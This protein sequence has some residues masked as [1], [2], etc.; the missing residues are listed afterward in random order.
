MALARL[1]QTPSEVPVVDATGRYSTEP[2]ITSL[3]CETSSITAYFRTTNSHGQSRPL[4]SDHRW[5]IASRSAAGA[6]EDIDGIAAALARPDGSLT[7]LDNWDRP[8]QPPPP[9]RG[10]LGDP[11]TADR[12]G[13]RL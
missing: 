5:L 4:Q 13:H 3:D 12:G 7:E 9:A 1:N 2:G 11:M 6:P 10:T 8:P